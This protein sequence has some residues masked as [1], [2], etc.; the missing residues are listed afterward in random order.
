MWEDGRWIDKEILVNGDDGFIPPRD[1]VTASDNTT[2]T[3]DTPAYTPTGRIVI[4][5][6]GQRVRLNSS[7]TQASP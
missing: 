4:I 7:P 3:I 5:K 6:P 1:V 2:I